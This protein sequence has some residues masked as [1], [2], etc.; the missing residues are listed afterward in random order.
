[1]A[2]D[3]RPESSRVP[4]MV[5]GAVLVAL[6]LLLL[7][8][9]WMSRREGET[10]SPEALTELA[11]RLGLEVQTPYPEADRLL[12]VTRRF[13]RLLPP[14]SSIGTALVREDVQHRLTVYEHRYEVEEA[15]PGDSSGRRRNFPVE[16][17]VIL[18]EVPGEDL[19]YWEVQ[20]GTPREGGVGMPGAGLDRLETR[21]PLA[22]VSRDAKRA[23]TVLSER[24][25]ERLATWPDV[26]VAAEGPFLFFA[27]PPPSSAFYDMVKR[28][29]SPQ[30][31]PSLLTSGLEI[32]IQRALDIVN[33]L[34]LDREP[35][36]PVY[37]ID[38]PKPKIDLPKLQLNISTP[39]DQDLEK[40]PEPPQWDDESS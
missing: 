14:A 30:L 1:M 38:V 16:L 23:T 19:P 11:L 15:V 39:Q 8:A 34:D 40:L 9:Q 18:I 24:A 10:Q 21:A 28:K 29:T 17:A 22:A 27:P 36:P 3:S 2:A 6:I 26:R 25:L 5:F 7:F 35:L 13:E 31:V 32:D 4:I 12:Q 20:P 33:L 37:R